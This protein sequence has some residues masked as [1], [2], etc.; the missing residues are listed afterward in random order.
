MS[1][2]DEVKKNL[3]EW[4]A[5]T[6][7]KTTQVARMTSRR[8]D[9]F[10]ISRDIERQFSELGSLIYNGLKAERT[11]VLDDTPVQ[12]LVQ[13]ISELEAELRAKDEEIEAI[14]RDKGRRRSA[15][16][17]AVSTII[18]DPPLGEGTEDSAI[19]LAETDATAPRDVPDPE[20][21]DAELRGE[22]REP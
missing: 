10:G 1:L 8:Y 15:A 22:T 11:D 4:Y 19:L 6:S 12:A 14:K 2:F 17:G 20:A 13:R 5:V 21:A 7:E 16:A 9:K 18:T 3:V